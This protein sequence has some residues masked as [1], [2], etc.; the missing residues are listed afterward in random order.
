MSVGLSILCVHL[1]L[2]GLGIPL[3]VIGP[4]LGG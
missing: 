1:F 2:K 4:W 3:P